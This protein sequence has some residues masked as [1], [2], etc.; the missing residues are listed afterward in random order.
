MDLAVQAGLGGGF[1]VMANYTV[2]NGKLSTTA[3]TTCNGSATEDCTLYGT[4]KNAYNIG[5]YYEDD[6]ISARLAYSYRTKYKLGNRG[7]S[8]YFQSA[9]GSLNASFNY[10]LNKNVQ[11]TLEAQNLLDPLLTV[12]KDDETQIAGVYKNGKTIYAGVKLKF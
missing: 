7:G 1:G 6:A 10:T 3:G 12:Y 8:D 4:S 2:V 9:N 5:V 11:F